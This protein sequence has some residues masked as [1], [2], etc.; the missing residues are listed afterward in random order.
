MTQFSSDGQV[1]GLKMMCI[2]DISIIIS[3]SGRNAIISVISV[4]ISSS[5]SISLF[6]NLFFLNIDSILLGSIVRRVLS[7]KEGH[8]RGSRA[9]TNVVRLTLSQKHRSGSQRSQA[10]CV[11]LG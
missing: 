1:H 4:I 11:L 10:V 3:S 5:S 8:V 7:E 2:R 6:K 9:S